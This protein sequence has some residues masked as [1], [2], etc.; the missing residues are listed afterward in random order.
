M[1]L[2]QA[3]INQIGREAARDVYRSGKKKF[4][5]VVDLA[6]PA[7]TNQG[8]LEEIEQFE[9]TSSVE[10]T[11]RNLSNLVERAENTEVNNFDWEEIFIELDN[12]IEFCR[13][14]YGAIENL[15]IEA[16]DKK[17]E[18]NFKVKKEEHIT[19]ITALVKNQNLQLH[20]DKKFPKL[21]AIASSFLGIAPLVLGEKVA[22]SVLFLF[23]MI[24]V[25]LCLYFGVQFLIHPENYIQNAQVDRAQALKLATSGAY[26]LFMLGGMLYALIVLSSLKQFTKMRDNQLKNNSLLIHLERYLKAYT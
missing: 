10:T 24:I 13:E 12:K 26:L 5:S 8:I 15:R 16:L 4:A 22:K 3:F 1:G 25:S 21:L 23:T 17:N 18:V 20:G 9:L 14:E 19:F 2:V 11:I 7:F 6:Q